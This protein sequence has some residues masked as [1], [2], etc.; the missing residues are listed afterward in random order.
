MINLSD[1]EWSVLD[2][3]W[4]SGGAAE[5]GTLEEML[6]R[7]TGWRVNT[8]HTYLTR[9]AG[10]GLV[11]IDKD[12]SPHIYRAA[13]SRED[14]Q[15]QERKKFLQKVYKGAAGDLIAAF[16]KEGKIS[17]NEREKLRKMLDEMEV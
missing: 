13:V 5:L 3:L 15:A 7:K 12:R 10:K 2:A 16:L 4:D 1:R 6:R 8:L 17:E 11:R 9:M 14:C